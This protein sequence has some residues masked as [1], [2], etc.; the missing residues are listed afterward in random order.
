MKTKILPIII[1]S[2]LFGGAGLPAEASADA[3]LTP[4]SPFY[5]L[6]RIT[7]AI[8]TFFT[9]GDLKKA[10]RYTVLAAERLAEAEAMVE[11]DK[12]K[13]IEKTLAR[14]EDQ[15]VKALYRADKAKTKGKDTDEVI[16]IIIEAT[17]KHLIVLEEVLEKVPEEAKPAIEH[18]MTVSTKEGLEK[19]VEVLKIEEASKSSKSLREQCIEDTGSPEKCEMFPLQNPKSFE[20]VEAFCLKLGAPPE[21]CSTVQ[22][23]CKEVGVTTPGKCFLTLLKPT[24]RKIPATEEQLEEMRIRN[25]AQE[26]RRIQNEAEQAEAAARK[27]AAKTSNPYLGAWFTIINDDTQARR[28]L[29]VN[30]GVLLVNSGGGGATIPGSPAELAGLKEG[31]I[32]IEFHGEKI[33]GD[34]SFVEMLFRS[35]VGV[36]IS[37]K[38]LR[39]GEELIIYVELVEW[40]LFPDI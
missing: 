8:G 23:K 14:Y 30:Y 39:G 20:A 25:E 2:L 1:L 5:F 29:F 27:E 7:E 40:P 21:L 38:V 4:D 24:I 15:L 32:I 3:G 11:K 16:K 19:A 26:A 34:N 13:L 33:I 17:D 10:E 28:G 36:P 9:F 35:E 37:L 12:P 31:D 22:A 18:A 6:E